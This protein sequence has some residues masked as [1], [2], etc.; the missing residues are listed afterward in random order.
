MYQRELSIWARKDGASYTSRAQNGA[1][2][3][4]GS[5][6]TYRGMPNGAPVRPGPKW[7]WTRSIFPVKIALLLAQDG[8]PVLGTGQEAFSHKD[9]TATVFS[10]LVMHKQNP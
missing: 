8:A 3:G 4:G 10:Q 5:V 7:P 6:P 1:P 2:V 9:C